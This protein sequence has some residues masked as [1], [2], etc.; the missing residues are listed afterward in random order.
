MH[1]TQNRLM[2]LAAAVL[3]A[4][5]VARLAMTLPAVATQ[6]DF[7]HYY[8]ASEPMLQGGDPYVTD[9]A[10]FYPRYGFKV[11]PTAPHFTA[12]N[13]PAFL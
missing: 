10:Q 12:P 11:T 9:L 2:D 4:V 3:A 7:T 5:G 1:W 8:L 6:E 13:P